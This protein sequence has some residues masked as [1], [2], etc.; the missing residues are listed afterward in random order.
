MKNID[1]K[2]DV[3]RIREQYCLLAEKVDLMN[4]DL[5]KVHREYRKT[6][7]HRYNILTYWLF[8]AIEIGTVILG[9]R[10]MYQEG[11]PM[12]QWN[13]LIT[14]QKIIN[15]YPTEYQILNIQETEF[16][17]QQEKIQVY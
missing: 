17:G 10:F 14:F 12:D 2:E 9:L 16:Y 7:I 15:M 1:L 13:H 6:K 8:V 3:C 11:Y 4:L 5:D